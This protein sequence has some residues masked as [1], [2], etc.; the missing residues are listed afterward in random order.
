MFKAVSLNFEIK[1][2]MFIDRVLIS[3]CRA[4]D[5]YLSV[6]KL[7]MQIDQTPVSHIRVVD[8]YLNDSKLHMQKIHWI[9]VSHCLVVD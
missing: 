4:I 1:Y 2:L 8:W 5:M 6:L 9:L 7:Q 3:H